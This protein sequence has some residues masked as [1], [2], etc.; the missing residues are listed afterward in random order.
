MTLEGLRQY[1]PPRDVAICLDY[2]ESMIWKVY[3]GPLSSRWQVLVPNLKRIFTHHLR[4]NDFVSLRYFADAVYSGFGLQ[5]LGSGDNRRYMID[6]LDRFSTPAGK[7]AFY[8]AV[9]QAVDELD[10]KVG[11]ADGQQQVVIALTDGDDNC[12]IV[13]DKPEKL[14][15]RLKTS[16]IDALIIVSVGEISVGSSLDRLAKA[17]R[18]GRYIICNDR[19]GAGEIDKAFEEIAKTLGQI[20]Q[21]VLE[22]FKM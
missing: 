4:V 15:A 19:Q 14:E 3:S 8:D 10:S 17:T 1:M 22:E 5:Q 9:G 7:T 18:Y 21:V 11:K 20:G 2:S 13:Y 16:K 6:V 12:S